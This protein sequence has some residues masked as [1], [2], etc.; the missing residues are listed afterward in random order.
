MTQ[1]TR[2]ASRAASSAASI[3]APRAARE[4]LTVANGAGS[5]MTG[6]MQTVT[7]GSQSKPM[8][9]AF[10]YG[11]GFATGLFA[12]SLAAEG[13]SGGTAE[14]NLPHIIDTPDG[15]LTQATMDG[16]PKFTNDQPNDLNGLNT[17]FAKM[18]E[19]SQL[20][21]PLQQK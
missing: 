2:A 7:K 20:R 1:V 16:K 6:T 5:T 14:R 19:E 3:A 17:A 8:T 4:A 9:S 21:S 18:Q 15:S 13:V 12:L 10:N 11:V